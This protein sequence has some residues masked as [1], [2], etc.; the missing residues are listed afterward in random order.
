MRFAFRNGF[1]IVET[2]SRQQKFHAGGMNY[3]LSAD[4]KLQQSNGGK[5][6]KNAVTK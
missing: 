1:A 5:K 2:S 4:K 3:L 6:K